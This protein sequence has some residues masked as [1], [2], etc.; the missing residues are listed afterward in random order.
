MPS[1][2]RR[3]SL[4]EWADAADWACARAAIRQG[5]KSFYAASLL[6]P[7]WLRNPTYAVYAFCR[8]SDDLVDGG[9][10]AAL[11]RLHARLDAAYA[12]RPFD[13][14]IDRCFAETV[15]RY[16]LPKALPA[17]LLEGLAWDEAGRSYETLSEVYAYAARVAGSVGAMMCVLMG[18]R[19]PQTLARACDLGVAMQLTNIARDV[20]E[21]ARIGRLYLPRQWLREQQI[22]PQEFLAEPRM[23]PGLAQ[24]VTRLLV[25]ADALYRR[26]EHGIADL[27]FGC[28]PAIAAAR[29]LYA[30]I[31][32]DLARHGYDSIQRRAHTT[33][34]HKLKL[35]TKAIASRPRRIAPAQ[36]VMPLEETQFLLA[37]VEAAP[38]PQEPV[39]GLTRSVLWVAQL[40]AELEAREQARL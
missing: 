12:G 18:V 28:R 10:G 25:T 20:G 7:G 17:A 6:L 34:A 11:A 5:S 15:H 31:G 24:L 33:L 32:S 36:T 3:I 14:P 1:F 37:A 9:S 26:A 22:D 38:P 16:S 4:P 19:A 13:D 29:H 39:H 2:R 8:V 23:S 27:P 21:D 40:L 30:A 35:M